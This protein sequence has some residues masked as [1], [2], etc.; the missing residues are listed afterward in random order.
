MRKTLIGITAATVL[1]IM[2]LLATT[3]FADHSKTHLFT[4]SVDLDYELDGSI[5]NGQEFLF[6]TTT[7]DA[8]IVSP[9]SFATYG[10]NAENGVSWLIGVDGWG[11]CEKARPIV[12]RDVFIVVTEFPS[13]TEFPNSHQFADNGDPIYKFGTVKC[14]ET[15][16]N[17]RVI[18]MTR[19]NDAPFTVEYQVFGLID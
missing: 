18:Q 16:D 14:T 2:G 3:A 12:A 17:Y 11:A 4:G 13:E 19:P 7:Y 6:P 9:I 5:G 1:I 10:N 15:A 8:Q